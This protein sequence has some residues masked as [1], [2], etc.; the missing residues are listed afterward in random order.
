MNWADAVYPIGSPDRELI[1]SKFL[2][3]P[4]R[5]GNDHDNILNTILPDS[6]WNI[7]RLVG[8][9]WKDLNG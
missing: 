6:Q 7:N 1:G 3:E 2:R 9:H 5:A 4:R 8:R